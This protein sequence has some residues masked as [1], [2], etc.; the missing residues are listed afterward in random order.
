MRHGLGT[1][2]AIVAEGDLAMPGQMLT[3]DQVQEMNARLP[4][5]GIPGTE[6]AK[7]VVHIRRLDQFEDRRLP[8][9]IAASEPA[10]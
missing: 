8:T 3:G 6:E 2:R 1:I 7:L 4:Y 10:T 9:P 5:V